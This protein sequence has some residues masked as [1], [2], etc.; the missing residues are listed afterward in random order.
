MIVAAQLT[1]DVSSG[2]RMD[3][4]N[5]REFIQCGVENILFLW[6]SMAESPIPR[7]LMAWALGFSGTHDISFLFQ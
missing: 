6:P 4:A 1:D 5:L 2:S 3:S 7:F